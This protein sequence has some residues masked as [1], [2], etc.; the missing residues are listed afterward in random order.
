M[1][2]GE[3]LPKTEKSNRKILLSE[4]KFGHS[5]IIPELLSGHPVKASETQRPHAEI[6]CSQTGERA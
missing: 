5:T 6:R 3:A 4:E 1:K 2:K